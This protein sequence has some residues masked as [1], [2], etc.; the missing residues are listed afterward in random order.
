MTK[1]EAKETMKLMMT[2]GW[3]LQGEDEYFYYMKKPQSVG[4][5]I[6]LA[7]FFWWLFFIPNIIYYVVTNNTKKIPKK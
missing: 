4:I 2:S 6:L 5:H 1:E 3:E 7:L